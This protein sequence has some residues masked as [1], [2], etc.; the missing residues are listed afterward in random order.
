MTTTRHF[1]SFIAFLPPQ[2]HDL[3]SSIARDG[4][5]GKPRK[6]LGIALLRILKG[7]HRVGATVLGGPP[8]HKNW[9]SQRAAQG[10]GPY[11]IKSL[12]RTLPKGWACLLPRFLGRGGRVSPPGFRPCRRRISLTSK[13]RGRDRARPL[14]C[15]PEDARACIRPGALPRPVFQSGISFTNGPV[16][17]VGGGFFLPLTKA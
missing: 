7:D 6:R 8:R 11:K 14:R 10:A 9:S 4:E 5:K 17:R 15:F 2:G 3:F 16:F 12:N 1:C 13:S